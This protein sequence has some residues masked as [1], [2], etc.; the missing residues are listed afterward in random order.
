MPPVTLSVEPELAHKTARNFRNAGL[1]F[2]ALGAFAVLVPTVATVVVEQL[3]ALAQDV[4][5]TPKR[6]EV[7]KHVARPILRV[8][9]EIF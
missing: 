6:V 4:R 3:I 7:V 2:A 8:I 9:T 5:A 1:V